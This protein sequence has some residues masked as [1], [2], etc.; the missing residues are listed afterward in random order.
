MNKP[1]QKAQNR[2]KV[3]E[4]SPTKLWLQSLKQGSA[5][6]NG[7]YKSFANFLLVG[8]GIRPALT[9]GNGNTMIELGSHKKW[10]KF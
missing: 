7:I 3:L 2:P 5:F 8:F 6:A 1:L 4:L 9:K 10:K